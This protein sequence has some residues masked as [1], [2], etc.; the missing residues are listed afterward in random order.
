LYDAKKAPDIGDAAAKD[1]L[2]RTRKH[3]FRQQAASKAVL[4]FSLAARKFMATW[5]VTKAEL[6]R[7]RFPTLRESHRPSPQA[8]DV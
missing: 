7:R 3:S 8:S 2:V 1:E 5:A 6:R 4:S